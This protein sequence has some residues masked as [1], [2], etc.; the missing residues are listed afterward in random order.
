MRKGRNAIALAA[1]G[2]LP[3]FVYACGG[4]AGNAET[5]AS[6][7]ARAAA[8]V[9][10][11]D[12]AVAARTDLISGVPVSG[13]LQP[14][15]DIRVNSPIPEI[16]EEILVR[17]GDRVRKGQVL[18][19]FSTTSLAPQA[20]SA[21]A[22]RRIAAADY[23]RMKNLF[24]EGAVSQKDVENAELA[25]RA[26]E[27]T[28]AQAMQRLEEATIRAAESGVISRRLVDAGS[29]VKDG[30]HLFQLVNT[31]EL[32]FEATVPAQYVADVRIGAP[33][34]LV[35]T[36]LEGVG[37]TGRVSRVN[38]AADAATRQ[39]KVYV[40]VPNTQRR[41]VGGLFASGRIVLKDARGAIAIPQAGL[42][43]GDTG[44]TYVFIIEE[45]RVARRDVTAG[46]VDEAQGMAQIVS[47]LAGGEQ[48]IVGPI[49]GLA[50]GDLVQLVG[51]EG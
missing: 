24:A 23:E 5:R 38:A 34:A 1:L 48:V 51:K 44:E 22:Q 9:G 11:S 28:A 19:R 7:S 35:V 13:S 40:S 43:T 14:G 8:M 26:A 39:V 31:D 20:A 30:D 12:V 21:E 2:L 18:A 47:G 27:A 32:E 3:A 6:D 36:G 10:P 15:V 46:I 37:V 45:G 50:V 17:E 41:M 49:E 29:R 42:K 4:E 25:L 33:V 16:L